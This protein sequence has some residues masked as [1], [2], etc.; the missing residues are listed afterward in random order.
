MA[1]DILKLEP[2]KLEYLEFIDVKFDGKVGDQICAA[3]SQANIRSLTRMGFAGNT[4]WF[5][6]ES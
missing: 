3:L 2:H 4:S 5:A 6:S 1:W